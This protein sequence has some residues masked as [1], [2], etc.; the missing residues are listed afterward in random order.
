MIYLVRHGQTDWNVVRRIQ[1]STDIPLNET[2][3]KQAKELSEDITNYKIDR[4]ICSDLSRA[5]ETAEILNEKIGCNITFDKR[6]REVNYGDLEG[7]LIEDFKNGEWDVFNQTPEK[8]NGEKK[9]DVYKRVKSFLDEL[10]IEN[11][12]IL[13]VSHGGVIRMMLYYKENGDNFDNEKYTK[14]LLETKINNAQ[15][16]EFE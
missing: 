1:G 12:N 11:E 13:V 14:F 5:R 2:G 9:L 8:L 7:R 6:L 3:R 10:D 16:Y 15:I 4:I